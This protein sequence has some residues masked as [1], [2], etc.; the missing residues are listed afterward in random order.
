[1]NV[2]DIYTSGLPLQKLDPESGQ[3]SAQ[4]AFLNVQILTRVITQSYQV[5]TV[6][7]HDEIVVVFLSLLEY[8]EK[9]QISRCFTI[10][11]F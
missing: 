11:V 4:I 7:I 1:M 6:M 8:L 10:F 5:S 2:Y 9:Y 3:L